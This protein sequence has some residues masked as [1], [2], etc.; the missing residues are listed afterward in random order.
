[1]IS[2]VVMPQMGADMTEGTLLRWLKREGDA[3]ERGEIIAEIETD[4][5]NIEIEAFEGGTFRK[6]LADEGDVVKV[7]E[8]IAVIADP[9][10]DISHYG[11]GATPPKAT[12]AAAGASPP[13]QQPGA[14]GAPTETPQVQATPV[15]EAP[16]APAPPAEVRA[17]QPTAG[18][19]Q[20]PAAAPAPS[21]NGRVRAS[22]LAR[23]IARERGIDLRQVPGS[24]PDGRILRSDVERFTG[25][26]PAAAAPAREPAGLVQREQPAAPPPAVEAVPMSRMRQA[27]ARRMAQSKREA[28]H[29][30][31]LLD[32]DMTE[33]M[34]FRRQ[35]ND[36][37]PEDGRISINDLI[38]KACAIAL[39][40][41]PMFNTTIE[42]DEVRR[43]E[44]Q[45]V[46]I[47]VA[48]DNGL[49]APAL[50]DAGRKPLAQIAREARDLAQRARGGALSPAEV[51][52]GTFS[53]TNLG[54]YGVETLI[55][56]IQPPQTAILGVG[57]VMEQPAA[58]DGAVVVRNMMKVALSADH[59]V[60]DGAQGAR[61]LAEIKRLLE[62]PM[63]LVL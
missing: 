43:H 37:L 56:I 44:A 45:N 17:P 18:A 57:T 58:R 19:T 55:G 14:A 21:A 61:F 49:I 31:L 5:A 33:A 27:I 3:V 42:G 4:K 28:P 10:D 32:I 34:A 38:V 15:G 29:Y 26:P 23:R 35:V 30:Y 40:R 13:A 36:A 7:G 41:H 51:S 59:R 63:L 50:L 39:Q 53:I 11:E 46:C 9:S 25:A 2:E 62:T 12:A 8:V 24:G 1:M 20:R 52:D 48:L 6:T 16:P 60:T 22:P 54:A 47:A